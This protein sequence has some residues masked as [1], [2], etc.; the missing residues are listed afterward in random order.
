MIENQIGQIYLGSMYS[1]FPTQVLLWF[2]G[3]QGVMLFLLFLLL[4]LFSRFMNKWP[5]DLVTYYRPIY[6][7]SMWSG[8]PTQ[9]L[10]SF[11]GSQGLLLFLL[12]LVL[13]MFLGFP[14]TLLVFEI[15]IWFV[16]IYRRPELDVASCPNPG[17]TLVSRLSCLVVAPPV[18]GASV[19]FSVPA[20]I[21]DL[22]N[23]IGI[24]A[25]QPSCSS[26]I[27]W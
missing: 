26:N 13:R 18:F 7:G 27:K 1:G 10:L 12:F 19:V 23:V 25:W 5:R 24:K 4:Q 3:F 17:S 21:S 14:L 2:P 9:V 15:W 16:S 6:L 20:A 11:L 22:E 8:F